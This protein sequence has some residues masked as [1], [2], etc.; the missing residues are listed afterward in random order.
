MVKFCLKYNIKFLVY[1]ILCGGLLLDKYLDFLEIKN[2]N[3]NIVS[4]KKYKN[5]IDMWGGWNLF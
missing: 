1:G 5:I 2:I 4:L 3:L